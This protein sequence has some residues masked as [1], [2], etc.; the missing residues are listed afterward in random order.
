[1]MPIRALETEEIGLLLSVFTLMIWGK[2][3]PIN[4]S[5]IRLHVGFYEKNTVQYWE[6]DKM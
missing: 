4:D 6:I 2:D 5:C 1:M 3:A